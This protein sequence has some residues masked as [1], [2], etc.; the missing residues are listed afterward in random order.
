MIKYIELEN[1]RCFLKTK[2]LIKDLTIIVGSNNAGK[3]TLIEALRIVSNIVKR[4]QYA[5][6]YEVPKALQYLNCKKGIKIECNK[7]KIDLNTIVNFYRD[8]I[9]TIKAVYENGNKIIIKLSTIGA[10]AYIQ[11]KEGNVAQKRSDTYDIELEKIAILPQLSLTR[12]MEKKYTEDIIEGNLETYLSSKHFRNELLYFK[13]GKFSKFKSFSEKTW[14]GLRIKNLDYDPLEGENAYISLIVEDNRFPA[15]IGLMGSGIQM[16]LQIIWFIVK[17]E[18]ADIIILDE[19]DV[20]MHPDLQRK[21]LKLVKKE[22]K[23]V[24]IATHSIEIISEVEPQNIVTVDK[25]SKRMNYASELNAVQNMIDDLGSAQNLSLIRLGVMKRCVF[26][27]GKD[28]KYLNKFYQVLY[29]NST[30]SL[31]TLPCIPLGGWSRFD[32]ALGTARLF[33]EETMGNVKTVCILDRDYHLDEE[34]S[35]MREKA[36]CSNLELFVWN[37]KEIENYLL[38]PQVIY[39][40]ISDKIGDYI[41]FKEKLDQLVDDLKDDVIDNFSSQIYINSNRKKEVSTCNKEAR[42]LVNSR[43][44]NLEWKLSCVNGKVAL[45]KINGWLQQEY[46]RSCSINKIFSLLKEED[47]SSDIKDVINTLICNISYL[48]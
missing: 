18:N 15:E 33:Y 17:S 7:L 27:E 2:L 9:A 24:I 40:I 43:W 26:V 38:L 22:F 8:E 12:E 39:R 13:Q 21:L 5:N 47:I 4:Y 41:I 32:E 29:P 31:E 42:S 14:E 25:K 11:S 35:N 16:W 48:D 10:Y 28:I 37:K 36:T 30:F 6:F 19:P 34:I 44:S 46:K 23:Q 45:S 1:Y 3:S 20:Y